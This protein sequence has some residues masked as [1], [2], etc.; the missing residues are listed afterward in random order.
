MP[1]YSYR[2]KC[3]NEFDERAGLDAAMRSCPECGRQAARLP[4]SGLPY[5]RGETVSNGLTNASKDGDIK[6]KHGKYRVDLWNENMAE[7][8][9][10]RER[11]GEFAH[12][13]QKE[14]GKSDPD[15]WGA[16]LKQALQENR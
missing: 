4:C 13:R 11:S 12:Q 8:K 7:V 5:L 2:C 14:M 9:R 10:D 6:N 16:A 1:L 3:G 15:M